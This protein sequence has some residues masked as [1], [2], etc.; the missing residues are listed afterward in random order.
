MLH[1]QSIRRATKAL[2]ATLA[3]CVVAAVVAGP[4]SAG[5]YTVPFCSKNAT[6]SSASWT[7]SITTGG[8]PYFVTD[9]NCGPGSGYVYR[10]FE[11][12]T[13]P[14]GASDDWTFDA[15]SGTYIAR[16]D[17]YQETIA[18]SSGAINAIY[19]WQQDNSRSTVAIGRPGSQLRDATYTFA[20]GGSKTVK[21]RSSLACQDG[22]NCGGLAPDGNY[23]NEDYWYGAVVHL[24]DPSLPVFASLGG[25][26]WKAAPADGQ[27]S[28]DYSLTDQGGG[29]KEVRYYL[30]GV[31]QTTRSA[32]CSF[33]RLVPCPETLDG[34]FT[35]DT[36]RLAE[37]Q[38]DVAITAVDASGNEETKQQSITVRRAPAPADTSSGGSPVSTSN[39]SYGGGGAPA[40][41]DQLQGNQGSWTGSG[42]SFAYQWLRCD[43]DGTDCVP[44]PGA[45][46]STY[47]VTSADLGH[48]LQFCV[49]ASNSG[50]STT[51]CSTPTEA[52]IASHPSTTSNAGIADR[53]GEPTLV[54]SGATQTS[55]SAG[56]GADRGAPNGS[57]ASEKVVLTA[58][59]NNRSSTRRVKF[60]KRTSISGRLVAPSGTPI[61]NAILAVQTRTS[62]PGASMAD[63]A[64]VVTGR[65][66]RFTY[67]APAGPSRVIRFGYRSYTRDTSFADTSDVTLKVTAGVTMKASPKKVKNRRATVFT[68][69]L[70]GKPIPRRGVVVDLQ[71][72]FRK[73]WRNFAA[74]RTNRRGAYRF[75]YRFMAGA[76]TW[77]FRAKVRKDSSYP[78]E[79]GMS[80]KPVRVKVVN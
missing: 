11:I 24:V 39:P 23:G 72:F 45:T 48:A 15:P 13:V 40:V 53:P 67:I 60:G 6:G 31:L 19:A 27:S 16:L 52:V 5:T 65:D 51:R 10:R 59:V 25:E 9:R 2:T 61:A 38:H 47:S 43:A 32:G 3:L 44:I 21:L 63:A 69:R 17:M 42:L 30:N 14:A 58:L 4:A 49:T 50:G 22:A 26:G 62:M 76:A 1:L 57:P 55:A 35:L 29:L 64:Q 80:L 28:I 12:W 18:R 79:I 36:T 73:Q 37:G 75:K 7:H 41:G 70:L 8:T 77:R 33:T 54:S 74:P 71:V 56:A 68:G 46:N 20:L 34:S 66:G 78:Y